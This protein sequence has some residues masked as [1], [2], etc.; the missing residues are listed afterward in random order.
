ML[1]VIYKQLEG[2]SGSW[3]EKI[4]EHDAVYSFTNREEADRICKV[5]Q[6]GHPDGIKFKV[7]EIY[8]SE[9]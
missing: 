5:L 1:Y 8:N 6:D 4:N 7:V 9:N 3:V 2:M